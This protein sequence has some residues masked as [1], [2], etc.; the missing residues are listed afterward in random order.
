MRPRQDPESGEIRHCQ[1]VAAT[2]HRLPAEAAIGGKD[3]LEDAI[4]RIHSE[5]RGRKRHSVPRR[6]REQPCLY[7][8]SPD[9]AMRI[10]D[11]NADDLQLFLVDPG[12]YLRQPFPALG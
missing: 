7:W 4:G 9:D 1:H 10:D 6:L 8:A 2:A 5:K 12:A 3:I 11:G